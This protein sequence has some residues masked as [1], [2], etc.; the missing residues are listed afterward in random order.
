MSKRLQTGTQ[1]WIATENRSP[2]FYT[3]GQNLYAGEMLRSQSFIL[4]PVGVTVHGLKRIFAYVRYLQIFS[5]SSTKMKVWIF[6]LSTVF[7]WVHVYFDR[8]NNFSF[9]LAPR[10][11]RYG[12]SSRYALNYKSRLI[13]WLMEG[14]AN[15]DP[16]NISTSTRQRSKSSFSFFCVHKVVTEPSHM[17]ITAPS[18]PFFVKI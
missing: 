10:V 6:F 2:D 15:L 4:F 9:Y 18:Q 11:M 12:L 16:F 3:G 13:S 5:Q 7:I 17:I 1:A 8:K 14:S